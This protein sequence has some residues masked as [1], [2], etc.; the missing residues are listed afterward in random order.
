MG[1]PEPK[2]CSLLN[3]QQRQSTWHSHGATLRCMTRP[4]HHAA[5][6]L[7]G[8][9]KLISS[10]CCK[11]GEGVKSDASIVKHHVVTPHLYEESPHPQCLKAQLSVSAPALNQLCSPLLPSEPASDTVLS[12]STSAILTLP[13]LTQQ[14][15]PNKKEN[16]AIPEEVKTPGYQNQQKR[17]PHTCNS[18]LPPRGKSTEKRKVAAKI[19]SEETKD[20]GADAKRGRKKELTEQQ[21]QAFREAFGLF[22]K[23]REDCI[24]VHGLRSSLSDVGISV[25]KEKLDRAMQS[26]DIDGDGKVNFEDFLTVLT[27]SRRLSQFLHVPAPTTSTRSKS[28]EDSETVFF[29][30]VT[31][32]MG[33]GALPFHS[34]REIVW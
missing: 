13:S 29:S 16:K 8:L 6:L 20:A 1:A 12:Q 32:M 10:F 24:D 28:K 7:P 15:E 34:M 22:N 31:T 25:G 4:A 11:T 33:L 5:V 27:D 26:A 21:V 3:P 30:A 19:C 18:T 23:N 14:P 17:V 2:R 9:W